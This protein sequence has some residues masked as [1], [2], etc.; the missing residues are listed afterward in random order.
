MQKTSTLKTTK[1]W[2]IAERKF[3]SLNES[4]VC[5][6][7]GKLNIVKTSILP[8]WSIDSIQSNWFT[9]GNWQDDIKIFIKM[10]RTILEKSKVWG[11]TP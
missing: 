3:K 9:S 4:S 5:S 7:S 1:H 10:Q 2:N 8:V 6:W 11:L